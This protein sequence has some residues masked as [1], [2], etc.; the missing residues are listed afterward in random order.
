VSRGFRAPHITDLGTLGLTGSGFT[1]SAKEIGVAGATV[2]TSAWASAISTGLAVKSA[3]P[4]MSLQYERSIG[5]HGRCIS[6]DA[7]FFANT[8][9]DNI[10][11][12]ALIMP[13]GSAGLTLGD[14]TITSQGPTGVVYV[15]ASSSPVLVRTNYGDARI[16]GFEHSAELRLS[17]TI[18]LGTAFTW[19]RAKDLASGLA[20]N[21]EGGTP[22]PD[23]Y[24]KLRYAPAG[25][26]YWVEPIVHAVGRQDRLSTLD[27]ED[28]R[29]G[30]NRTR[31][32]IKNFFYNG[33]TARGWVSAG[34]DGKAGTADD[35]LL[36]TGETLAQIQQRVLGSADSAA[37]FTSVPGYVVA[38]IR[39][40]FR[41]GARQQLLF[42]VENV[43]DRNY[44]G[45]AWGM[46]AAGIGVSA[47]YTV[48]F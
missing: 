45:I 25:G 43:T 41:V 39:G 44:R 26:R 32:N 42:E 24:L 34:P 21:I 35:V 9:Y 22:G 28:R 20:P 3:E 30:A 7:S 29:T 31:S 48:T 33:A 6:T 11:Y 38:S 17:S 36:S 37:L 27:L 12:Q 15:P 5:Y 46:D 18:S 14:Q 19:I 10:V 13:P 1:V 23:F 40:G 8:V 16:L 4:E 47:V 2:G